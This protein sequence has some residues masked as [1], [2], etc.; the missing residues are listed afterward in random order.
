VIAPF[1]LTA[2]LVELTPGPNMG[3]L[4]LLGAMR[5]RKVALAAVAGIATGLAIAG[6]A[7]AIGLA[8]LVTA[9]PSLFQALRLAGVA[10]VLWLAYD[11]WRGDGADGA[12]PPDQPLGRF[13][14]QGVISNILNPKA[15]LFYI[16]FLP[17]FIETG[18]PEL[19]QFLT[20]AGLYVLVASGVHAGIAIAAGTF[21]GWLSGGTRA[22]L[23]R[24][25]A[26][27]FLVGLA[28]WFLIST[29]SLA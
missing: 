17:Q 8:A 10:Y 13:F 20:L 21:A 16:A 12:A 2:L 1:L 24:R 4:A 14:L 25:I 6:L 11:T 22:L 5:G 29:R 9:M 23:A 19:P 3:W 15:Y 28:V 27:V 18:A 7:A 26:A